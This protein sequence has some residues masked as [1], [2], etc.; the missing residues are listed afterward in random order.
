MSRYPRRFTFVAP[1]HLV[2]LDVSCPHIFERLNSSPTIMGRNK[3]SRLPLGAVVGKNVCRK[4]KLHTSTVLSASTGI[5]T[6]S[7]SPTPHHP[8]HPQPGPPP[9]M[10]PQGETIIPAEE[11]AKARN[12]VCIHQCRVFC[13]LT[14]ESGRLGHDG[15][16][17]ETFRC[18][19]SRYPVHGG[20]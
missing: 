5:L 7:Y 15:A 17:F 3:R 12:Q 10:K 18:A 9:A 6:T 2:E 1:C 19:A 20:G 8:L 16:I 11:P 14:W 13:L 4:P